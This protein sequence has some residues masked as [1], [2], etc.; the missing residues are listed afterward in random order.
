MHI[1]IRLIVNIYKILFNSY[2]VYYTSPYFF[3]MSDIE[4][5]SNLT[6][7]MPLHI[8]TIRASYR[9]YMSAIISTSSSAASCCAFMG[10]ISANNLS[11]HP[12]SKP[13]GQRVGPV[14]QRAQTA[15]LTFSVCLL[16]R[17]GGSTHVDPFHTAL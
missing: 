16:D 8:Q 3:L 10:S 1:A 12:R 14:Q 7:S 13:T 6:E 5:V 4:N 15:R 11:V 2:V 9:L 17:T